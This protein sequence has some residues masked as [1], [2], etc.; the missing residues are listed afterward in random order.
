MKVLSR[1]FLLASITYALGVIAFIAGNQRIVTAA[2]NH[3]VISQIQVSGNKASDEFVELYNP[4]D[5]AIS[6]TGWA[7][8][9]KAASQTGTI[10]LLAN[11]SGT[12]ASHGYFL[13]VSPE[14]TG[15]V[16]GDMLYTSGSRIGAA[17]NTILLYNATDTT[18]IDTV[19]MGSSLDFEGS[20]AAPNPTAGGSIERK[21]DVTGGDGLDTDNNAND[22]VLLAASDPRNSTIVITPTQTPSPP[23]TPEPTASATPTPTD[24][25]IPTSTETPIPTE[26]S[27]PTVAIPTVMPTETIMPT[28]TPT[29]APTSDSS[30]RTT[31]TPPAQIIIN[32]PIRPG[33]QFV[34]VLTNRT[35]TFFGLHVILPTIHCSLTHESSLDL[36][37]K[38]S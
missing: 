1:L 3:I 21:N 27:T 28:Q 19:G 16:T 6:L 4:T 38:R 5:A 34:C 23:L 2:T 8:K 18:P 13:I 12:I 10:N 32:K 35:L 30:P 33:L 37:A 31:L 11:L 24:I 25:P 29:P 14:Y 17:D 26:T 15:N 36:K 22:F 9:R 20:G 7:L